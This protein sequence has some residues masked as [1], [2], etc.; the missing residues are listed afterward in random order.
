MSDTT[1]NSTSPVRPQLTGGLSPEQRAELRQNRALTPADRQSN[2]DLG[3]LALERGRARVGEQRLLRPGASGPE[4]ARLKQHLREEG[5][6]VS[7]G[8]RFD[9]QTE[10]AVRAFQRDNGL[11][12]DGTVGQ[13]TWGA[14][15][16]LTGASQLS[17]GTRLLLPSPIQDGYVGRSGRRRFLPSLQEIRGALSRTG[18][19]LAAVAQRVAGRMGT[20]GWCAK[21]VRMAMQEAGIPYQSVGSAYQ[22]ANLLASNPRF[23]EVRMTPEQ[24]RNLPPGAVIVSAPSPGHQHGHIAVS[25]GGGREA[26]DHITSVRIRP[27]QRVFIPV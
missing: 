3:A 15:Y 18:E 12:V 14:M 1:V 10:R 8:D 7:D 5:Y 20:S 13:Q 24:I 26:S 2:Q 11:K 27:E 6:A 16:G 22:A 17:P 25:L 9:P 19:R 21:G 4:V 23:R